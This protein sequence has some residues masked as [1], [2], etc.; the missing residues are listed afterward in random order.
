[1][2]AAR[3]AALRDERARGQEMLANLEREAR[4]LRDQLLRIDGAIR[5]LEELSEGD[6]EDLG[7]S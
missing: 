2:V 3:L 1:M 6:E 7:R 4:I 5:V